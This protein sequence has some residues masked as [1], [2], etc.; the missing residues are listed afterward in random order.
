VLA[1]D[2]DPQ[3]HLGKVLG[4]DV[5]GVRRSAL[6]LLLPRPEDDAA[7]DGVG[8]GALPAVPTRIP[9]LD[10]VPGNKSLALA[11]SLGSTD[12]DVTAHLRRNLAAA[13]ELRGY[14][15]VLVDAPAS[16]GALT[17]SALRAVD[18]VVVPV[19]L[20]FLALDGCAELC[21]TLETV[22]TRYAHPEL[23]LAMVIPTF[24]RRT[25]LAGEVL[26]RLARRFPK[27]LAHTVLGQ[28]VKLDEAQGRGLSIF[29]YAPRDRA[30]VAMAALIEELELRRPEP[31]G[32]TE[33]RP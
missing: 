2:L 28:H 29:E 20:T 19:P 17:L 4:V 3:G 23:A 1:I 7:L 13:P 12:A 14:D 24:Y 6:D 11:P 15:V 30:A 10:L 25:R 8:D 32:P 27:E 31:A 21:R 9:N 16:F 5:H 18:E 33:G 22:R 26:E